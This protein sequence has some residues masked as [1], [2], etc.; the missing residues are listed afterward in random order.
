MKFGDIMIPEKVAI[1]N[2]GLVAK[3]VR[4][5]NVAEFNSDTGKI[6]SLW[7]K[8]YQDGFCTQ[9]KV[10]YGVYSNYESGD[11][12]DYDISVAVESTDI[13]AEKILI[14]SGNYLKFVFEGEMPKAVIEGWQY[15]WQY[16]DD[17]TQYTRK[18]ST[19]FEKYIPGFSG[20]EV[21]ISIL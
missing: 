17:S 21:Y 19:D 14:E 20:V 1:K 10:S 4:T 5:N 11:K 3:T 8:A 2:I 9:D 16:F 18:Y 15:I 13:D 6:M 12:G 7:M